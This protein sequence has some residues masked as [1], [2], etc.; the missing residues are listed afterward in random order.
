[1]CRLLGV[2]Y[3][4]SIN[5]EESLLGAKEEKEAHVFEPAAVHFFLA[6]FQQIRHPSADI[7][8]TDLGYILAG[9]V[10]LPPS[11]FSGPTR[12]Q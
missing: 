10:L 4:A 11:A 9:D 12:A 1:M 7:S 3:H 8:R 2:L 6:L 5:D